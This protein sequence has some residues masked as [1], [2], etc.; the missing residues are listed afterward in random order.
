MQ[1]LNQKSLIKS[2]DDDGTIAGYA[3]VFNVI[4]GHN[5][6]VKKGAFKKAIN[7][8]HR[9]EKP[10]LLWQHDVH[11]P[12]GII[13]IMREDDYGL[14]VKCKLLLEI[15]KANEAYHLLK[16]KVID[17][18][19]IGYLIKN[20]HMDGKKKYLTELDLLEIS[21]VTFPACKLAVVENVKS[22]FS[23]W[24]SIKLISNKIKGKIN[25]SRI[26][27]NNI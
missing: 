17:G 16:N 8:L 18:F 15:Q 3:S 25:E 27:T 12:I 4:D 13:E 19:S 20:S 26:T 21:V 24:E 7:K 22:D 9:G 14:F 1:Y 2:I 11:S 5:D 6:I 10:K 23:F